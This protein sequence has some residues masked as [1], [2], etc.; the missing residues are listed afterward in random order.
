VNDLKTKAL[1][2]TLLAILVFCSTALA[3]SSNPP[4]PTPPL[5]LTD[6]Q[7]QYPLGLHMDLLEDP[8]G[9]LTVQDVSSPAFESRFTPSS[10]EKPIFGYT[11]SAYWVR[12]HL[13]NKSQL[14]NQWLL[15]IGFP[16]T[17]NVDLNTPLTDGSGFTVKQSG[18]LRTPETR[19]L[20]YPRITFNVRFQSEI[21]KPSTCASRMALQ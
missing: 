19:D 10:V 4:A 8:G 20:H 11:A 7:G 18:T 6:T 2:L 21:C 15:E 1:F 9:K 12:L 13:D 14:T 3:Q 16:N 17:Q 5:I